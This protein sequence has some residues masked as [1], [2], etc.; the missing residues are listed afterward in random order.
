MLCLHQTDHF[1]G[2]AVVVDLGRSVNDHYAVELAERGYVCLAPTYPGFGNYLPDLQALGYQSGTMKAIYDNIRAVDLLCSLP[3]VATNR[4]GVI[5]HSLGGHSGVFTAVFEP[6]IRALVSSCGFDSFLD[7]QG[8]DITGWTATRYMP[9]LLE[10]PLAEIPF[11]F[12]ELIGALA[13]ASVFISAPLRDANFRWDS[14]DRVVTAARAVFRLY[15]G[16]QNLIVEHPDAVHS[17]LPDMR[18]KAYQ[19]LDSRLK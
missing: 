4:I 19:F 8:G 16:E 12:H 6:R 15:G 7:Y 1:E 11:D 10:W 18:E 3:S 9:R 14:V 5:G 13:P 2:P 17:F